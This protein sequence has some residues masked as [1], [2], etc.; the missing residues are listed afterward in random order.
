MPTACRAQGAAT[1]AMSDNDVIAPYQDKI[2]TAAVSHCH[3][4]GKK[5][6]FQVMKDTRGYCCVLSGENLSVSFLKQTHDFS[7]FNSLTHVE[8]WKV[9]G[10][11]PAS[12]WQGTKPNCTKPKE[13]SAIRNNKIHTVLWLGMWLFFTMNFRFYA[14]RTK[15]IMHYWPLC[16]HLPTFL[17][18]D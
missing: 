13:N 4:L 10:L 9:T 7:F 12:A 2:P 14:W 18:L 15:Y 11:T 5:N 1:T 6:K 8:A 3:V 17:H 16:Q